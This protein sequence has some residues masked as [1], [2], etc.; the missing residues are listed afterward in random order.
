[1]KTKLFVLLENI[2][3]AYNVGSIFRTC[4]AAGVNNLF[5]AGYTPFPPHRKIE[6]TALGSIESV[7]WEHGKNPITLAKKLKKIG[8]KL[9]VVESNKKAKS[10][11]KSSFSKDSCLIFGNEVEGVSAELIKVSDEVVKIPQFG[12]KESLNVAV[13]SGIAIYDF[14]MKNLKS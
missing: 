13:A 1:M 2:R 10:I 7:A 9:I 5:L 6:K 4:D 14:T 8:I 11:F 3:S 12:K